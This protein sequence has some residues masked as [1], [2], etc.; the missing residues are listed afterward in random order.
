VASDLSE[1]ENAALAERLAR[2]VAEH[3]RK[4]EA[5]AGL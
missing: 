3:L 1:D 5:G 4:A 2:P